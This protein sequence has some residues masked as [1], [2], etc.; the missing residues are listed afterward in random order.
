MGRSQE[1]LMSVC[2]SC[3]SIATLAHCYD[4][5]VM[6]MK[7]RNLV[8]NGVLRRQSRIRKMQRDL[9]VKNLSPQAREKIEEQIDVLRQEVRG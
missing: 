9:E 7:K 8:L 3:D 6:T 2:D 1:L 5:E 4:C